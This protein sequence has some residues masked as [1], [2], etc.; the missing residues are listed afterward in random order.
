M[1]LVKHLPLYMHGRPRPVKEYS[2]ISRIM[3]SDMTFVRASSGTHFDEHGVMQAVSTNVP[4]FDYDPVTL[5]P[6]GILMEESRTNY[7]TNSEMSGGSA[8]HAPTGWVINLSVSGISTTI[9]DAGKINGKSFVDFRISGTG[10]TGGGT[11]I[12]S[13]PGIPTASSGQAWSLSYGIELISGNL[14]GFVLNPRISFTG[15]STSYGTA[16]SGSGLELVTFTATAGVGTTAASSNIRASLVAG[17]AYDFTIR[18]Y[19]PQLELGTFA[20]SYIPTTS[21]AVTRAAD[22]LYVL[23]LPWF[24]E[25]EGSF[26]VEYSIRSGTTVATQ[27]I[28]QFRDAPD[29]NRYSMYMNA[30]NANPATAVRINGTTFYGGSFPSLSAGTSAKYAWSYNSPNTVLACSNASSI[31]GVV[32]PSLPAGLD[33]LYLG[34]SNGAGQLN[35]WLR[36]FKY[37]KSKKT[38]VELQRITA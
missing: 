36:G 2:F 31:L 1:E 21:T 3:P 15:A 20:T 11:T 4:R 26:L 12:V 8:G 16:Y 14:N 27:F 13:F 28:A 7:I 38:N 35:G 33:R 25:T 6:R 23:G 37:W 32:G 22:S 9:V 18:I 34:N 10:L 17:V 19:T 30:P 29:T 5:L 24:N